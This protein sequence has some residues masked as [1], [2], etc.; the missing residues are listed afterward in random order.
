MPTITENRQTLEALKEFS[1]ELSDF[2]EQIN[3]IYRVAYNLNIKFNNLQTN[4][5]A[6]SQAEVGTLENQLYELGSGIMPTEL[7]PHVLGIQQK[8]LDLV[9]AIEAANLASEGQWFE[10]NQDLM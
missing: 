2:E 5:A 4:L 7:M 9:A 3:M 10:I 6:W 8:T 1:K